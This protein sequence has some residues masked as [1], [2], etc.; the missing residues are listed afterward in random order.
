MASTTTPPRNRHV[1]RLWGLG[2]VFLLVCLFYVVRLATLELNSENIGGHKQDGTTERTVIVQ[3]VRGQIYDRNG[4]PLVTNEYTYH[5]TMDYSVLPTD[6][7]DRNSAILQAVHML[8]TCGDTGRFC[9]YDFPFSGYYPRLTYTAVASDPAS[10]TYDTFLS[11]VETNG[12][13]R[14]AILRAEGEKNSTILVAQGK[15]E[16]MILEAEAEKQ[17]QILRA[18]AIK[19]SK[20]REAEGEAAAILS[21]QQATADG[22]RMINEAAPAQGV[23]AIKSLEALEKVADGKATKI[24]IPSEMQ[25]LV[26]LANGIVEGTKA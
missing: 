25:G 15:K 14:E 4:V 1:S 16:S 10:N 22:I 2:G 17:S 6:M 7:A 9:T 21:I 24:I 5:L 23:I 3:A 19:E 8:E 20:I 13:R 11:V 18:E 12:L 26:G